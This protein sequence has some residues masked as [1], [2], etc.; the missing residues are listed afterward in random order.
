LGERGDDAAVLPVRGVRLFELPTQVIDLVPHGFHE[1]AV[2]DRLA[3][4]SNRRVAS[5]PTVFGGRKTV[6]TVGYFGSKGTHLQGLTELNSLPA[7]LALRSQCAPGSNYF[8]QA[9]AFTP[10]PCQ[11]P[12]YAFRNSA[13]TALQ[14]NTNVVGTTNF[15]D[16]AILDQLRPYRGYRSIAIV[17]PRYDSNYHSLQ[18]SAGHRFS[19][20]S[21]VDAYYTL[22]KNLTTSINDRSTSPQD[23]NQI[24][25]EKQLAAFDRRHILSINYTYE[26]P[27]FRKQEGVIGKLLG[28]WQASGIVT[29]NTGLPFTAFT[30]SFD[31]A[32]LG[33]LNTNPAGRP[34]LLCDPNQGG[35][36]TLEQYFNTSCFQRNPALLDADGN[37]IL[38]PNTIGNTARGNI[39]GPPTT[40]F[41]LTA[42][43]NLRF[44]ETFRIQL[45]A[46]AFNIFNQA[47]FRG[48]STN[49][50]FGSFGRVISVRDPRTM[51]F[52]A[53][54][55]F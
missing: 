1:G 29:Y 52:G 6:V 44:G 50:T 4:V 32:G 42:V 8:G 11:L 33:I 14:G 7:G 45:R 3:T 19:G 10:V 15:N 16:I 25:L 30:S 9:A 36:G 40:R 46:E 13:T 22:S 2:L 28:G 23:A 48:L 20:I 35:A 27:V 37:R 21:R 5:R 12:G 51:Q 17:Q 31:P 39:I 54:M 38:V 24:N 43:K 18:V 47:N 55:F 34:N 53:K 26:I 41:D 49:V